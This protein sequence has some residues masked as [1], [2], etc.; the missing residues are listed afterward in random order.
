MIRQKKRRSFLRRLVQP[1]LLLLTFALVL[2]TMGSYLA[3]VIHPEKMWYLAFAGLAY[4]FLLFANL[5][6]VVLW[7]MVKPLYAIIPAITLLAGFNVLSRHIQINHPHEFEKGER[8]IRVASY[9][10]HF[11][12]IWGMYGIPQN[13]TLELNE[14]FFLREQVDILCIQEGVTNH[15]ATGNIAERLR[16]RLGFESVISAG[17]FDGG[18][19]GLVTLFNGKLLGQGVI[20]QHGRKIAVYADVVLKGDTIRIYNLHLQSIRLGNQEYVMDRLAPD[21][22]RDSLFIAGS[23]QIAR[24][25]KHSFRLR[26]AEALLVREHLESCTLPVIL[27]GDFNDTPASFA[28]RQIRKGGGLSDAF[29]DAGRGMGRTYRGRF[30]SYRI[31]Y[32]MASPAF[33]TKSFSTTHN[34]LSDHHPLFAW[35]LLPENNN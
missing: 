30:P 12:N 17:Y 33:T 11:F 2:A 25:L 1:L 8:H 22:Y 20:E 13:D 34:G 26:A 16:K 6:A 35:Y 7:L 5:L 10:A 18:H 4:P 24:K 3:G 14:E 31:D 21:A 19:T 15:P 29:V 32:I 27:C 9:N 23:R 28:Y